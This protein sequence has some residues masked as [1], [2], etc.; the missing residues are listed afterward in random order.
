MKLIF[1]KPQPGKQATNCCHQEPKPGAHFSV[2]TISCFAD[3]TADRFVHIIAG[4]A[5][6]SEGSE[7][8]VFVLLVGSLC[9]LDMDISRAVWVML[10]K[11]HSG[12]HTA[13]LRARGCGRSH[14]VATPNSFD[15]SR[16]EV[17][18]AVVH[19]KWPRRVQHQ[20]EVADSFDGLCHLLR[21]EVRFAL[22]KHKVVDK[23]RRLARPQS[24]PPRPED[25]LRLGHG[26][27]CQL[28][29]LDL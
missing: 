28:D 26:S 12:E 19:R 29:T 13:D 23:Q 15:G 6:G 14:F 27:Q 16:P 20:Q 3:R 18:H 1:D 24:S 10:E 11:A 21:N 2:C 8:Q 22:T 17:W 9:I 7:Q 4:Q 5:G 25:P